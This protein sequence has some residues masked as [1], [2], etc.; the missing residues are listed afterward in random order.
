M[1]KT[2]NKSSRRTFF[3]KIGLVGFCACAGKTVVAQTSP[4]SAQP[5]KSV[6][7]PS[8]T[9][10]SKGIT[11]NCSGFDIWIRKNNEILACY[12]AHPTQKYPYVYP[13]IGPKSGISLT[14]ETALPWYH[15]RSIFFG[16][17][18]VNG[19]DYWSQELDKGK[20][21]SSEPK[22]VQ[23][24][25]QNLQIHDSCRWVSPKN[26][27]VMR[28]ER[29]INFTFTVD[30]FYFMDWE[31]LW[32]AE[33]DITIQKTNHSLFS[34]RAAPDI[35]PSEGG[36]LINAKGEQGEKNTFGKKSEWCAF[37]GKR[38]HSNCIEGIA[39]LDHPNNPW[40]PAPWFTRDY[41]FISPTPLNFIEKPLF[42][43]KGDSLL[44]KYRVVAFAGAPDEIILNKLYSD[45][46][47]A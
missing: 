26:E 11:F 4:V 9:S 24:T 27:V 42:L 10:D 23:L 38:K 43:N 8:P 33:V 6:P 14:T 12:R 2:N 7:L 28:D 39:L 25:K 16:C 40:S 30:T 5:I 41:G 13:L 37:Y 35:T 44:L 29:K 17:D 31:I 20:I 18:R 3:K 46:A 19:D 36:F 47:T 15:H 34:I 21:I 45:W 1:N 32:S 22:V